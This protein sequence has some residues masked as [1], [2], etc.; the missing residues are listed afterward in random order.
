VNVSVVIPA[1]NS[2]YLREALDSVFAQTTPPSE[3]ILVDSSPESTL[4]SLNGYRDRVAYYYQTPRGVSAARNLGIQK[5][6]GKYVAFL[7]ADDL[8]L[9]EKLQKQVDLMECNP[10]HSFCFSTVW[11]LV[12]EED[13]QIPREAFLPLALRQ[14]M[15]SNLQH[16]GAVSGSV[17]EL[18][19]EVNC[20]ATSSLLIRRDVF[21]T[22]G[23]FDEKLNHGEDY[24]FELRLARQFPAV[25]VTE[26]T[27]RYRVHNTGLSGGWSARSDLF[28]RANLSVLEAHYLSHPSTPLRKALARTCVGYATHCL[29]VGAC[30]K[31][32]AYARRSLQLVPSLAAFKCYTEA[33]LPS[34]YQ[35]L[36]GRGRKRN[37]PGI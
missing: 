2:R 12:E 5:A 35:F 23:G 30:G 26:P 25:Y 13:G 32:A 31:S 29:K 27:S 20:I 19:L 16:E 36:S 17:Y 22:V 4:A 10:T 21:E 14:W 24:D 6:H 3:I 28:Y 15:A 33:I 1:Y 37:A 8:W 9:P 18:L 34:T 11:N 7:D